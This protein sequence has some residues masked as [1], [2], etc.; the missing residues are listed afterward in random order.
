MAGEFQVT[1]KNGT[2]AFSLKVHRGDGMA[3]L[4]MNWRNGQ[5]PRD[6]VGFA[7]EYRIPGG[8]R[9]L[10]VHNR[11][12]FPGPAGEVNPNKL[13]SRLSPIQKFRWVHFPFNAE[14]PGE[15]TYMVTPVFM[16]EAQQLSYGE[17]Q[18]ADIELRR[19]TYPGL[20]NVA[21]TRGFVSSQAFVDRYERH[22]PIDTLLPESADDGLEFTPTHPKAEDALNWMGFEGRH[23]I[24]ETLDEAIADA[25]AN[26]YVVAYDLSEKGFV[27][28][29]RQLGPRLK[30]II[31]DDGKHGEPHSGETQSADILI[32]SAGARNVKRQNMGKLQHNK[33]IVVEGDRVKKAIGGSTNFS[34][35]GFYVQSNNAI[36]LTGAEPVQ[37]FREAFE[38]FWVE[39]GFAT[40]RSA[41][42]RD[43]G[44]TGVDVKVTFSPHAPANAQLKKIADDIDSTKSSLLFSL[45]FLYQTPGT[46]RDAVKRVR[47]NEARFVY[48]ISDKK[49]GGLDVQKPDGNPPAV[50]PT[51][52]L[53]GSTPA[54]F[55]VEPVGGG[56]NR[57][58]HK[59]VVI[60]FD[61]PSARVYL[62]SYNF[63]KAADVTNGENLILARDR[64]IAVSYM[65]EALRTFDHYH[66]R[67][68]LREA[69]VAGT[70][71]QLKLPPAD[72]ADPWYLKDYTDV[73]RI[74]DREMF[75]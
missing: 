75:S 6:F 9:F 42:W 66:F 47:D 3:L 48:G 54:P 53:K 51:A 63:S 18:T 16:D 64:R 1:G 5:P 55:N 46:I 15:Y 32:A 29:L 61:K 56:G 73:R 72:G 23:A 27:D 17:P 49:V 37:V 28:R 36:I 4:A 39:A 52:L 62:G 71:L 14:I 74:K 33:M 13:S 34:W 35:R 20:L 65:V 70:K 24:Y 12:A 31:D 59:F 22:G 57:M 44:I 11:I 40:S 8:T 26:V 30:I 45:A 58:H 68:A 21:Y 19:E 25:S 38:D 7:I 43:L 60:D 41:N 2:A 50:F 67:I 69:K 10:A